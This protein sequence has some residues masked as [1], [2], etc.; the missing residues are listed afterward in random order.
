MKSI[1]FSN[2]NKKSIILKS[3]KKK[4]NWIPPK[5][6]Y[7]LIQELLYHDP[8]KLLICTIFLQKSN[9][10]SAIPIFWEFIKRWNTP[11]ALIDEKEEEIEKLIKPLGLQKKR[12]F[13]LKKFSKEYLYKAWKY[14]IE[15]HGIGKYGNDSYRIFCVNEWKHVQ[16]NDTKLTLYHNWLQ[17]NHNSLNLI[18]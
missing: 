4:L 11:E 6:P 12:A 2:T 3:N 9:G 13:M 14:P 16:P 5:S 17:E 1:Y 10:K 18:D 15:L 8:W 7:N